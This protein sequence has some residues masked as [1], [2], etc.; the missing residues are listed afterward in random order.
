MGCRAPGSGHSAHRGLLGD[1]LPRP[2]HRSKKPVFFLSFFF[3]LA[4]DGFTSRKT[5][6]G[7][8]PG[9]VRGAQSPQSEPC[10]L[11]HS[12]WAV[13]LKPGL[14]VPPV[15]GIPEMG[16]EAKPVRTAGWV[17]AGPADLGGRERRSRP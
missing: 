4:R 9:W 1:Q 10:N 3:F 11:R 13:G 5:E 2:T 7:K 16:T 17:P 15:P 8:G 14:R 12:D 6:V